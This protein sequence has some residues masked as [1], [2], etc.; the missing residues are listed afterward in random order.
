MWYDI[1]MHHDHFLA[2]FFICPMQPLESLLSRFAPPISLSYTYIESLAH[3]C[4]RYSSAVR[5]L[6][7]SC[8]RSYPSFPEKFRLRERDPRSPVFHFMHHSF[9]GNIAL[10][11]IRMLCRL[12]I[13]Q[14]CTIDVSGADFNIR[15]NRVAQVATTDLGV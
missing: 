14:A 8:I 4:Y 12:S 15:R 10:A 1:T 6:H 7:P 13:C 9:W 5:V 2:A 3:N 11:H